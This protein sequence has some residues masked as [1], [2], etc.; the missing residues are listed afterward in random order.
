[1]PSDGTAENLPASS[2]RAEDR[3]ELSRNVLRLWAG[4]CWL[5]G[6]TRTAGACAA[7]PAAVAP[8]G[9]DNVPSTPVGSAIP[10]EEAMEDSAMEPAPASG[11]ASRRLLGW[12]SKALPAMGRNAASG[13]AGCMNGDDSES[14][15][16]ADEDMPRPACPWWL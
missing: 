11:L 8:G 5:R 6:N 1:M 10:D 4:L 12:L 16:D 13:E 2:S 15:T 14:G 9:R 3:S 7:L